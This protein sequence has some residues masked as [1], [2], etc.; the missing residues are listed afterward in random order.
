MK[1]L[2]EILASS[3]KL[4]YVIKEELRKIKKE[5]GTPRRTQIIEDAPE[6]KIDETEMIPKED[7]VVVVTNDGYIK[8]VSQRAY[9]TRATSCARRNL[10][11]RR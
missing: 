6:I 5:Y 2:E 11:E 10:Y 1:M 3:E 4:D 9:R 8:R 7:V